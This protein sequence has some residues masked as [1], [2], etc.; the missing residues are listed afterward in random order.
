MRELPPDYDHCFLGN[1]TDGLFVGYTGAMVPERVHTPESSVWYKSDRYYPSSVPVLPVPHRHYRKEVTRLP[2]PEDSWYELAPLGRVWYEVWDGAG[3]PLECLE[4]RQRF[5]PETCTLSTAARFEGRMLRVTSFL[6]ESLPVF[7]LSVETDSD[8]TVVVRA[9]PG[10][11]RPSPDEP[12]PVAAQAAWSGAAP[13]LDYRLGEVEGVQALWSEGAAA[14][15]GIV[16]GA[17]MVAV[18][19]PNIRAFFSIVDARDATTLDRVVERTKTLGFGGLLAEHQAA[20]RAYRTPSR[21]SVPHAGL[22]RM[23]DAGISL[24]K[25]IQSPASGGIPVGIG[26]Q[27]WSSHLFWDAYFPSR[28]LLE[29]GHL[30]P[31]RAQRGFLSATVPRAREHAR[32]TFRVDGLAWD[33]ELTHDGRRA[34]GEDWAHLAQQVHNTAAYSNLLFDTWRFSGLTDDARVAQ[35]ILDGVASFFEQAVIEERPR[36]WGT[37]PLVGVH[38]SAM[39]VRDDAFN[40]AGAARALSNAAVVARA[41]ETWTERHAHWERVSAGLAKTALDLFDGRAFQAYAGATEVTLSCLAPIYPM[42]I[43]DPRDPRALATATAFGRWS[44]IAGRSGWPRA[45]WP[46]AILAR[47][48]AGQGR[49]EAA[50]ALLKRCLVAVN[51]HGGVAEYVDELGNWNLQYFAT[52]HGALCSAIHALLLQDDGEALRVFPAVPRAWDVPS[53]DGLRGRGLQV[54][55]ELGPRGIASVEVRNDSDHRQCRMVI[56]GRKRRVVA[57]EPGMTWRMG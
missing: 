38:E 13:R 14:R 19:G 45:I 3:R 39:L 30:G 20:W 42:E 44:G 29:A 32:A 26:R 27:T 35:P 40:L 34:Y 8:L 2:R 51:P 10:P 43:V 48:C 21:I 50:V 5:D 55:A 49:A 46:A 25:A 41:A 54:S 33:W 23:Y 28:A 24:F 15:G 36:G 7:G 37:R 57:I 22:Q 1:G 53:F 11:W 6:H 31:V 16:E 52:A 12:M 9:A 47:V 56:V 4:S 18:P 17:L